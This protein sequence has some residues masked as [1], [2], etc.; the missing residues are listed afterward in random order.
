MEH[1]RRIPLL[2]MTR[3]ARRPLAG[4]S[5]TR[6][7]AMAR[8]LCRQSVTGLAL[9]LLSV[10]PVRAKIFL[11]H[12]EALA[13]ACGD[14]LTVETHSAYL[15]AGEQEAVRQDARAPFTDGRVTWSVAV[16]GRGRPRLYFYLDTHIVRTM[17]E[18]V[19]IGVKPDGSVHSVEVLAF[20]EPEDYLAPRGWRGLWRDKSLE[21]PLRPGS[22]LPNLSG[23]TLTARAIGDA[24]RRALALHRC[25]N[26][27]GGRGQSGGITD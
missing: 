3:S 13:L 18:T 24:V 5:S 14:S 7:R 10:V 6:R 23:A 26:S 11:T 27:G 19:L 20:H 8:R 16:D 12:Q 1:R 21:D 15:D 22:D 4:R 25:L 17:T 2:S 9:V